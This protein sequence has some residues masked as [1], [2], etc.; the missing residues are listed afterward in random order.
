VRGKLVV[1]ALVVLAGC[2][3]SAAS[4]PGKG[5][6]GDE[7]NLLPP[8]VLDGGGNSETREFHLNKANYRVT[9]SVTPKTSAGCSFSAVLKSG[10]KT[11]PMATETY[12]GAQQQP[13]SADLGALEDAVY[14]VVVTS[15]CGGWRLAITA[16]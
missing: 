12:E 5:Q 1:L 13:G 14:T 2:G 9:W 6:L 16:H 8:V 4:T 7:G 3:G 10:E 11:V 15:D